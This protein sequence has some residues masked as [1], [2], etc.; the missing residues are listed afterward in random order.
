M[1]ALD[2]PSVS[3]GLGTAKPSFVSSSPPNHV[4]MPP[5]LTKEAKYTNTKNTSE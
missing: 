1:Q 5:L 3:S 2:S 4:Y